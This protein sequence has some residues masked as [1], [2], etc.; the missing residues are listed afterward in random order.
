MGFGRP[1]SGWLFS[2][3]NVSDDPG[4]AV[5]ESGLLASLP[6]SKLFWIA[7]YRNTTQSVAF[8]KA[9]ADN[10]APCSLADIF[11]SFPSVQAIGS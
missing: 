6:F 9:G 4:H 3:T 8:E 7:A 1:N 2:T 10:G 5:A 11:L